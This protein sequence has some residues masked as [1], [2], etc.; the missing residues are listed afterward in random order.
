MSNLRELKIY[1]C[2]LHKQNPP[3]P[4]TRIMKKVAPGIKRSGDLEVNQEAAAVGPNC[5]VI[6][7]MTDTSEN[8]LALGVTK[9]SR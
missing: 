9:M 8:N 5:R 6:R 2:R 3:E 7:I 4:K 1:F